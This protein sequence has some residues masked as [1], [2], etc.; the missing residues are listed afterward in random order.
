MVREKKAKAKKKIT[1]D[2]GKSISLEDFQATFKDVP[3]ASSSLSETVIVS[4]ELSYTPIHKRQRNEDSFY[5]DPVKTYPLRQ[6][7]TQSGVHYKIILYYFSNNKF[8][9]SQAVVFI[10]F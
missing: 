7:K 3:I 9:L 4:S 8:M 10:E 5:A 6:K 1:V 2:S